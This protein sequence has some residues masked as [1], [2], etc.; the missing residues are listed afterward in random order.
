M[1]YRDINNMRILFFHQIVISDNPILDDYRNI[2]IYICITYK[3]NDDM[4]LLF[5]K[6]TYLHIVVLSANCQPKIS[7]K[8]KLP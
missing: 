3:A 8:N 7:I 4:L 6:V 2:Y 1:K 5:S